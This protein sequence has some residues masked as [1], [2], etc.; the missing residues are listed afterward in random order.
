MDGSLAALFPR[1][2]GASQDAKAKRY[3]RREGVAAA[4]TL[5]QVRLSYCS[6]G[7]GR[8]GGTRV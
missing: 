8:E 2:Q 7:H 5:K 6:V 3:G 4:V 1:E